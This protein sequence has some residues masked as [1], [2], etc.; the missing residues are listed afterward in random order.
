MKAQ[1]AVGG[2]VAGVADVAAVAMR[3]GRQPVERAGRQLRAAA[4]RAQE[5]PARIQQAVTP[6]QQAELDGRALGDGPAAG[7]RGAVDWEAAPWGGVTGGAKPREFRSRA[8][9]TLKHQMVFK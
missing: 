9:P 5:V 6:R 8:Q 3:P 2:E 4:A 1:P 7:C